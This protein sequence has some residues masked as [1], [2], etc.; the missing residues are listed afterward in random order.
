MNLFYWFLFFAASSVFVFWVMRWG[1]AEWMEGWR[2]LFFIDWLHA[3]LW[4]AE[5]IK[6]YFLLLWVVHAAWFVIGIFAPA[7]RSLS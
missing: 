2:S 7:V 4:N 1:G 5:Q 6:L 3:S